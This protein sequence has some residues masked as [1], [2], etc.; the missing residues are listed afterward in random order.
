MTNE[1]KT[2]KNVFDNLCVLEE[3]LNKVYREQLELLETV[4]STDETLDYEMVRLLHKKA[5]E[6]VG[7][8]EELIERWFKERLA[9]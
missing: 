5:Y 8:V 2:R 4:D 3:A 9:K 6:H 7:R 1:S